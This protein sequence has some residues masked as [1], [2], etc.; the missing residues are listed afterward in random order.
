ME[1]GPQVVVRPVGNADFEEACWRHRALLVDQATFS[2]VAVEELLE[3][4]V[5]LAQTTAAL[6][7]RLPTDLTRAA[8]RQYAR[9]CGNVP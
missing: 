6:R 7:D 3:T 1:L 9:A 4:R 2:S 5:L 8:A